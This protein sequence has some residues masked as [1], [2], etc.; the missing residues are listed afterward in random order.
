MNYTEGQGVRPHRV[1]AVVS[2]I[3]LYSWRQVPE[4]LGLSGPLIDHARSLPGNRRAEPRPTGFRVWCT[5]TCWDSEEAL[6]SFVMGEPHRQAMRSAHRLAQHT[7]FGRRWCE[8]PAADIR[9]AD[10]LTWLE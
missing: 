4:L 9:W 10:A 5:L 1:L 2:E 7:R 8:V 3:T 6:H